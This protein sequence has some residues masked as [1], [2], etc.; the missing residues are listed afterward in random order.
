MSVCTCERRD[1][2]LQTRVLHVRRGFHSMTKS[3]KDRQVPIG[4]SVLRSSATLSSRRGA[5]ACSGE[6]EDEDGRPLPLAKMTVH[7]NFKRALKRAGLDTR[8]R[9]HDL[10]HTYASH[11]LQSGGDIF[12]LSRILGQSSVKITEQTYAPRRG[13]RRVAFAMPTAT[14]GKGPRVPRTGSSHVPSTAN[15]VSGETGRNRSLSC[16]FTTRMTLSA[17]SCGSSR[18]W[19]GRR[20][21]S[22]RPS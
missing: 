7:A 17:G 15:A 13:L 8:L 2:D 3:G 5:M 19:S 20:S 18:R 22:A 16:D 14:A 10:R 12:K 1:V 6:R 11:Y 21:R 4:D 9:V